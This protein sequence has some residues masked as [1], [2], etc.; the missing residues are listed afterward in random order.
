MANLKKGDVL[1]E[2]Q[3]SESREIAQKRQQDTKNKPIP[4]TDEKCP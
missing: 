2:I 3:I 1:P 4:A